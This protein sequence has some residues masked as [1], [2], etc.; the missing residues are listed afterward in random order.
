MQQRGVSEDDVLVVLRNPDQT[1]LPTQPNRE[2]YRKRIGSRSVDVVFEHDPTQIVV[3]GPSSPD[4]RLLVWRLATWKSPFLRLDVSFNERTGE[5]VAAY[6][7]VREGKVAETPG[8]SQRASPSLIGAIPRES[9]SGSS[10]LAPCQLAV[11]DRLVQAEP[12]HITQVS[13]RK[14]SPR[15]GPSCSD[16]VMCNTNRVVAV[17][18]AGGGTI[19][20]EGIAVVALPVCPTCSTV[21]HD[22]LKGWR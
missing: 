20:R 14:P 1:G 22:L 11:L 16:V 18:S 15:P 3:V 4:A 7:R 5:A 8:R 12:E 2:R 13:S 6:L 9:C 21:A 10:C 19:S 17:V